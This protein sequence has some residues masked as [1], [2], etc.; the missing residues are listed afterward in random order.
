MS[1]W[2]SEAYDQESGG[3]INLFEKE[4]SKTL[5]IEC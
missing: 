1:F 5:I 2:V 4:V 3:F